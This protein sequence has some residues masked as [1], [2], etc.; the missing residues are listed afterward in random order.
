MNYTERLELNPVAGFDKEKM[1]FSVPVGLAI[2]ALVVLVGAVPLDKHKKP[3]TIQA[4]ED[5][6]PVM[7]ARRNFVK[8]VLYYL[9]FS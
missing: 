7:Q 3:V 2:L 5:P 6:D 1:K 8:Q 9:V 4:G